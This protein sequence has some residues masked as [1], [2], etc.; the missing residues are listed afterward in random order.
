MTPTLRKRH[1][2]FWM[3]LAI[4]LPILFLAAILSIPDEVTQEELYLEINE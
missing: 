3:I 2:I 4:V 1:R